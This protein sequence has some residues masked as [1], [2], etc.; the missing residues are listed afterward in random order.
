[1]GIKLLI[2]ITLVLKFFGFFCIKYGRKEFQQENVDPTSRVDILHIK[3]GLF[4]DM[5][6]IAF[7]LQ[8]LN[9][10]VLLFHNSETV[11]WQT[12]SNW[13]VQKRSIVSRYFVNNDLL[14]SQKVVLIIIRVAKGM[15]KVRK[16]I[17]SRFLLHGTEYSYHNIGS[18]IIKMFKN[19]IFIFSLFQLKKCKLITNNCACLIFITKKSFWSPFV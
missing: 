5:A 16:Q 7:I 11:I 8:R 10:Y 4:I 2:E 6:G 13:F 19:R 18:N 15:Q 17:F 9:M 3:K 14:I 12:L 1:M